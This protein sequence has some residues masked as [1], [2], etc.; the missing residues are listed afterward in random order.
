MKNNKSFKYIMNWIWTII[1]SFVLY[2]IIS[3]VAQF[4]LISGN[5]MEATYSNGD[6][7]LINRYPEQL[8]HNDIVTFTYTKIHE[9]FYQEV[10]STG[11]IEKIPDNSDR[12]NEKHIKRILGVPGDKVEVNKESELFIND[13]YIHDNVFYVPIQ[14]YILETGEYFLMGDNYDNSYDSRLHG[15]VRIEDIYGKI[16]TG[17]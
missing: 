16:I 15:P 5:S 1:F 3:Q 2:L 11:I 8:L 17:K 4:G 12:I 9:N 6:R 10:M 13:Q 7:V 14:S